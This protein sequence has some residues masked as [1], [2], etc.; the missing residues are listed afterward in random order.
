MCHPHHTKPAITV[1]WRELPLTTLPSVVVC[2]VLLQAMQRF[3]DAEKDLKDKFLVQ[4]AFIDP[5]P[6]IDV[7][8]H[9]KGLQERERREQVKPYA[10]KKLKSVLEVP[11]RVSLPPTFLATSISFVQNRPNGH[12]EGIARQ[13]S[14]QIGAGRFFGR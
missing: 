1:S 7:I 8:E 13:C 4:S 6:S 9:W 12:R 11:G 14:G 5:D 10:E 2:A 3:P